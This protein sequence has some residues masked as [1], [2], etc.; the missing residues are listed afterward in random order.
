M[1]NYGNDSSSKRSAVTREH[2]SGGS[3]TRRSYLPFLKPA[4]SS[5]GSL[6]SQPRDP[7]FLGNRKPAPLSSGQASLLSEAT[8]TK[9]S[10]YS[11]DS[12]SQQYSMPLQIHSVGNKQD[13]SHRHYSLS[14]QQQSLSQQQPPS[15]WKRKHAT[16][17]PSPEVSA[18][19]GSLPHLTLDSTR[20]KE[21]SR[22]R[23]LFKDSLPL[24]GV[25]RTSS[26]SGDIPMPSS[27]TVTQQNGRMHRSTSLVSDQTDFELEQQFTKVRRNTHG[28]RLPM[29]PSSAL[30]AFKDKLTPYEKDEILE[31]PEVWFLGLEAK[32]IEAVPGASQ[33]SGFD[34]ENGNYIKMLY[35]HLAYRYEILEVIGKGSFGQVVKALDH[36]TNTYV[37]VKIIRNKKRFHHQALVEVKILD[38][39]RKKDESGNYNIIHMIEYF[40]F[41]NH[42]CIVFELMGMNLY[43]L[44]KKHNFQGFSI[45]LIRRIAFSL[46]HCLNLLRQ[47]RI[48][49]CDLKPENILMK[50][51]T[52]SAIKVIDFGSSCYEHQ[53][54]YTYIQS[55]F[56]RSPEVILG[57]PYSMSID[58]W[59]F[60]CI[61]AE[62]HTGYPLFPGENEVEQLAC[63]MEIFGLPPVKLLDEAQRRKIFFDSKGNPRCIVNSKGKRH[64]P[65][66]KELAIALKT[67]DALFLD[68]IKKC[69]C[70]DPEL[71]LTPEE[72]LNHDWILEGR[73]GRP[74]HS[75]LPTSRSLNSPTMS[76]LSLSS[77]HTNYTL[78]NGYTTSTKP[79]LSDSKEKRLQPIGAAKT[80]VISTAEIK[81]NGHLPETSVKPHQRR[82]SEST[83]RSHKSGSEYT[84]S[85][86]S[87]HC[88]PPIV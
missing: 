20:I 25:S 9:S 75:T 7:F 86:P 62:L 74:A 37:A 19:V 26:I 49:H 59:S 70:W 32:K 31:Y 64:R 4:R 60:G 41:R 80:D 6:S 87:E 52:Q 78:R 22:E 14:Y 85:Q 50:L 13:H 16:M 84:S 83:A 71:R 63:I 40:Y 35:D 23:S 17:L 36:K 47:Q 55:R 81:V 33:N 44:I 10:Y 65:A 42:L 77:T 54:I 2:G 38:S 29:T 27:T 11:Q 18:K 88:L 53:R 1:S 45:H 72:A 46:L 28:H 43:E 48:I 30:K 34:D 15:S 68:F 5:R 61:L 58:M 21:Q 73:L 57:L 39:L 67:N 66:T 24:F 82:Y 51:G 79:K 3:S 12:K 8:T 69:L 76:Q 56:Y